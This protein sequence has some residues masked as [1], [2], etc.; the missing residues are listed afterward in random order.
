MGIGIERALLFLAPALLAEIAGAVGGFGSSTFFVPKRVLGGI[1]V[2]GRMGI[3][4]Q[5][6]GRRA[7]WGHFRRRPG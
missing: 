2:E 1:A 3:A 6:L 4:H 7:Q 5:R